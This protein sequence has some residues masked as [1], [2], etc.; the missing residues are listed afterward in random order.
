MNKCEE[1]TKQCIYDARGWCRYGDNCKFK[2]KMNKF[3]IGRSNVLEKLDFLMSEF[4]DMKRM[5]YQNRKETWEN[6]YYYPY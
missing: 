3:E 1:G 2:H 5:T 6:P 4:M